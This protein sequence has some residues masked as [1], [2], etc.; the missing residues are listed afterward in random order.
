MASS[1]DFVEYV[2]E[3][4]SGAGEITC[5][6]MFGDYGVYCN[7]K[8]VGVVCDDQL[9]IKKTKAGADAYPNCPE[10]APYDG[11]KPHF[12]VDCIDD[13]ALMTDFIAATYAELP[14]LKPKK[15]KQS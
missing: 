7:G 4:L 1:I 12:L 11:A 9:F 6:K 2:R 5:K 13:R 15:K 14:A 10:A 8:I 3:Q